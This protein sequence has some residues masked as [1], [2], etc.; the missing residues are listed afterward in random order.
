VVWTRARRQRRSTRTLFRRRSR[1][2][3]AGSTTALAS[4]GRWV[5]GSVG[6][7]G[8]VRSGGEPII[9]LALTPA[10]STS[11][12]APPAAPGEIGMTR[13]P[14]TGW[15]RGT[16]RWP[17]TGW[18]RGPGVAAS[19]KA[20][21]RASREPSRPLATMTGGGSRAI[22]VVRDQQQ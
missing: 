22:V 18:S 6:R 5:G 20:L 16:T 9:L 14:L 3:S 2:P 21:S 19:R 1:R 4:R 10:G 17:L 13:R 15:P 11:R 7:S 8:P 12:W